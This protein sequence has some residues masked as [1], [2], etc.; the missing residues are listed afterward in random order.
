MIGLAA[1]KGLM[2]AKNVLNK[3]RKGGGTLL[4]KARAFKGKMQEKFGSLDSSL[5]ATLD[6][7]SI[8]DENE[9][10][11]K[12]IFGGESKKEREEREAAEAAAAKKKTTM[13][14]IAAAAVALFLFMRKK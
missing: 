7:V 10:Q 4:G 2:I 12:G 14:M 1:G 5:D 3:Q 8:V 9:N 11:T 13:M 6:D